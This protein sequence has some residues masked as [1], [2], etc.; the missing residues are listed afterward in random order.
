MV[1]RIKQKKQWWKFSDNLLLTSFIWA[2]IASLLLS[3][4]IPFNLGLTFLLDYLDIETLSFMVTVAF[5]LQTLVLLTFLALANEYRGIS[6][7]AWGNVTYGIGFSGMLFR[8]S[9]T[10]AQLIILAIAFQLTGAFFLQWGLLKFNGIR[11]SAR[12]HFLFGLLILA[13][14]TYYGLVMPNIN[15]RMTIFSFG[16]AVLLGGA[17]ISLLRSAPSPFKIAVNLT[18]APLLLYA[19]FLMARAIYALFASS[20][21]SLMDENWVQIL[22]FLLV[23]VCSTLWSGGLT[24]MITQRLRHDL[25]QQARL[26]V[27]TQRPNRLSMQEQLE[28]ALERTTRSRLPLSVLILDID[29]FKQVNDV[30]GH[31]A[32]D[33]ILRMVAER[34][35]TALRPEDSL[36]RWGG[37]EFVVILPKTEES[38]ALL[39]AER[40]R[41]ACADQPFRLRTTQ[42]HITVSIGVAVAAQN[43]A[44]HHLLRAADGA[45]YTAKEAGR[46]RVKAASQSSTL[47][48]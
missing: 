1:Q 23:F 6:L 46:N 37:E 19:I 16:L 31:E 9:I 2:S 35:S 10:D 39:V 30:H 36:G 12:F 21:Q 11:F 43:S 42:I 45:L 25:H 33:F 14:A 29:H 41:L 13:A 40:L 15:I 4:S 3:F 38:A 26:D 27:L 47:I 28:A 22:F 34:L 24:L 20:P 48:V 7:A 32:G 44:L 5:F 8:S 17:G 18:G